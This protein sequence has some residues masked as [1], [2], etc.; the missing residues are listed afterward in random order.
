MKQLAIC[1][2]VQ[3][4]AIM[5]CGQTVRFPLNCAYT[6]A[7]VYSIHF[8]D[9]FASAANPGALARTNNLAAGIYAERKFMLK[10]LAYYQAIVAVPSKKG[11]FSL[12]LHYSGNALFQEMQVGVG[13]GR[14]LSE[15]FDLGARINYCLINAGSYSV[16]ATLNAEIGAIWHINEEIHLGLHVYNPIGGKFGKEINEKIPAIYR[17]GLGY[18]VSEKVFISAEV[19]KVENQPANINV[20]LQ[21]KFIDQFFL[22]TGLATHNG[23]FFIG[24]GFRRNKLQVDIVGSWHQQLGYTTSIVFIFGS[25]GEE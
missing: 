6:S 7:G 14:K 12:S 15:K 17:T 3:I 19:V 8:T 22:K 25:T 18:E 9:V 13:Y 10:E 2:F 4:M 1:F 24:A 21:Y 20:A 23:Q 16:A 5:L 11:G